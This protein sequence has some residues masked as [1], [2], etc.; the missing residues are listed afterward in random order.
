MRSFK[1]WTAALAVLFVL[2]ACV[3]DPGETPNPNPPVKKPTPKLVLLT[4]TLSLAEGDTGLIK[5]F[6]VTPDTL[7]AT[8]LSSNAAIAAVSG[9]VVV[10]KKEGATPVV[11][12][13]TNGAVTL[14]DTA[15]VTVTKPATQKVKV[16]VGYIPGDL[17]KNPSGLMAHISSSQGTF[18]APVVNQHATIEIPTPVYEKTDSLT[19]SVDGS[20][21][22]HPVTYYF[23]RT[24][25][26][27]VPYF[28]ATRSTFVFLTNTF[29]TPVADAEFR[30]VLANT[31]YTVLL[32]KFKGQTVDVS[33]EKLYQKG[34]AASPWMLRGAPVQVDKYP[35]TVCFD[36]TKSNMPI[37]AFDSTAW[38]NGVRDS[39]TSVFGIE[40]YRPGT[41]KCDREWVADSTLSSAA[42]STVGFY[43]KFTPSKNFE[44][45]ADTAFARTYAANFIA[46]EGLHGVG[47]GH[48]EAW[49]SRM[50][51]GGGPTTL[52]DVAMFQLPWEM[53]LVAIQMGGAMGL[54][55]AYEA[56]LLR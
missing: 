24:T 6:A 28:W 47:I 18:S 26:N 10:G 30:F 40:L 53:N 27:G 12:R 1:F 52:M 54:E 14:T 42:G 49:P 48:T 19:V 13:W 23:R 29:V 11:V 25:E 3:T 37:T 45:G 32:G 36:R 51:P 9:D 34:P 35:L 55:A 21:F 17:F 5:A 4:K 50:A 31:T 41:T 56:W 7:P 16:F 39:L 2:T 46:H 33:I 8:F 20:V 43:A 38:W 44:F 22:H 15:W